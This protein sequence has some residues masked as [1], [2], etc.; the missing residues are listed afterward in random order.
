M[1]RFILTALAA[2][3]DKPLFDLIIYG[4]DLSEAMAD[5]DATNERIEVQLRKRNMTMGDFAGFRLSRPAD[6]PHGSAEV[7]YVEK[8]RGRR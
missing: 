7:V 2:P 1:K 8:L 4:S 5:E 3:D 6:V